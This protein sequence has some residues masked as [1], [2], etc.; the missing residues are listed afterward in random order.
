MEVHTYR[1][2]DEL[3]HHVHRALERLRDEGVPAE[4]IAVLTL[5]GKRAQGILNDDMTTD[6]PPQ[7]GK[8]YCSTVHAFKGLERSV[9]ILAGIE[10]W[11]LKNWQDVERLLYVGSSRARNHLVVVMSDNAAQELGRYFA[12]DNSQGGTA[13][14]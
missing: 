11:M 1:S 2:G 13:A 8:V 3:R 14:T 10:Q 5:V 9:I 12:L 4:E 6:W 7:A